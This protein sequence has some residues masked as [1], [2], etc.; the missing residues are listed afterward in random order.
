MVIAERYRKLFQPGTIGNMWLKNRLAMAPMGIR[1]LAENDGL[2]GQ[3]AIDYYEERAKGGVG[4][5]ISSVTFPCTKFDLFWVEEKYFPFPRMDSHIVVPGLSELVERLH[6]YDCKFCIQF[7]AGF[8]RVARPYYIR[9][10]QPVSASALRNVW[11]PSVTLRALAT[12]EVEEIVRS[13]GAAARLARMAGVDAIELH[14]H[15]GYLFDQFM[16][17]LWNKR[18][19]KYGGT[20]IRE[21]MTFPLEVIEN[22]NQATEGRLPII[23]RFG[24]TH[25]LPG[26]RVEEEGLEICQIVEDAGVAALDVDAGCYDNWYWPHPPVYHPPACM[27]DMAVKAKQ[28]VKK[29]PVMCVGKMNYPDI[30]VK[31]L[32]EG[33]ADFVIIGRGLLADPEWPNKTRKGKVEEIRPCIGCHEG[34][35]G[36]MYRGLSLSC[37]VNPACGNEQTLRLTSAEEK[38]RVVVV[39]GGPAGMEA[40]RVARLRGHEVIL[41][42]KS[43]ELG[44]QLIPASVPD[45]KQDLRLLRKY[46]ENEMQRLGVNVFLNTQATVEKIM[47]AKPD[48]VLLTTG[49]V[50]KV[51][52][53]PGIDRAKVATAIEVL[54][55]KASVGKKPVIIGGGMVGCEVAV[56]LAQKGKKV[57]IIEMLPR[58]LNDMV[59]VHA[60]REMLLKML[61]ESDITI[62]TNIALDEVTE[63]GV[64]VV[65]KNFNKREIPADSVIVATGLTPQDNLYQVL[66]E[67]VDQV[68]HIGDC[69][70][71]GR[72]MDAVWQA[73]GKAR[74]I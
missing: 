22:I 58:V 61:Q 68:Y 12:E 57:T 50:P 40:A 44:G 54:K 31:A 15:E 8:G 6:D 64:R 26:G 38:K 71:P 72:I 67:K 74:I 35:M 49:A 34:C 45:F 17:S 69:V 2:L 18:G 65:D 25:K 37:A 63:S 36:R 3:R 9:G 43:G 30:A 24:L 62:L 33:K 73:Y 70:T 66:W 39:G 14:C 48:V 60:N 51:P 21:R 27:L 16:T 55:G 59:H 4:L 11:D 5:I 20:T 13:F 23:F 10:A 46:Y 29:I 1:G 52:E 19:D 56:Y 47:E 42:E 7:T 28:M 32:E 41:Y 53:V